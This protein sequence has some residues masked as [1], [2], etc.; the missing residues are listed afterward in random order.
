MTLRNRMEKNWA[1]EIL[2]WRNV[3]SQWIW[4]RATGKKLYGYIIYIHIHMLRVI[5]WQSGLINYRIYIC[6]GAIICANIF[7]REKETGPFYP[8]GYDRLIVLHVIVRYLLMSFITVRQYWRGNSAK[9]M[10]FITQI[11]RWLVKY[12]NNWTEQLPI[13]NCP[14]IKRAGTF[15]N[16]IV[17]ME[18]FK[19]RRYDRFSTYLI[20]SEHQQIYVANIRVR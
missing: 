1:N 4:S 2:R 6:L 19:R 14:R 18:F 20:S 8:S 17:S 5:T 11:R 16:C 10:R 9:M 3:V 15:G 13:G 12:R 7:I